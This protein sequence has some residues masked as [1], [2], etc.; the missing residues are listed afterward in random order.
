M[1]QRLVVRQWLERGARSGGRYGVC[2]I[3]L[4]FG[5]PS[6]RAT[7]PKGKTGKEK[8]ITLQVPIYFPPLEVTGI[9]LLLHF[10]EY[11]LYHHN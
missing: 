10:L 3:V 5:P 11:L 8:L 4:V 1:F 6:A 2:W 7:G 9:S